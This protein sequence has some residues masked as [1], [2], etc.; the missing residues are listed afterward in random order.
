MPV[1]IPISKGSNK[2]AIKV[3]NP[4][5]KSLSITNKIKIK[6]LKQNDFYYVL[7]VRHIGFTTLTS[8]INTTAAIIMAANDVFGM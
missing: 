2:H 7:F 6:N 4:G 1:K 3:P 8:T 5:I